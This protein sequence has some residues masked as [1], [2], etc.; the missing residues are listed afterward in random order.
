MPVRV[1]GASVLGAWCFRESQAPEALSLIEGAQLHAPVL[2][3]YEL[4]SIARRKAVAYPDQVNA[5]AEALQTALSLD[6]DWR[7][8]AHDAVFRLAL[9]AGLT[10]YDAS[11]LY[12]ARALGASLATFDRRLGRAAHEAGA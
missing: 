6:I 9:Q 10:A 2:L 7:G 8:V 11:Y 5:L 12:L 4:T 1:V 3:A